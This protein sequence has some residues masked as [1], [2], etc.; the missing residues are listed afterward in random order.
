MFDLNKNNKNAAAQQE[1]KAQLEALRSKSG[2]KV[3]EERVEGVDKSVL[4]RAAA[5]REVQ[6]T[7]D[8]AA[9]REKYRAAS[10]D[11]D[12]KAAMKHISDLEMRLAMEKE[13][14][15]KNR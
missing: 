15:A 10:S 5:P 14:N 3:E 12:K 8:I 7:H 2:T 1:L 13:K 4:D 9:A 11:E 6:L